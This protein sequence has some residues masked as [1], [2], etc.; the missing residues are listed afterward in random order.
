MHY[1][2]GSVVKR[3]NSLGTISL[4]WIEGNFYIEQVCFESHNG[5]VYSRFIQLRRVS[6]S[7]IVAKYAHDH[8]GMLTKESRLLQKAGGK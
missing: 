3:I 2:A 5:A 7:E 8:V 4:D 1:T 6:T